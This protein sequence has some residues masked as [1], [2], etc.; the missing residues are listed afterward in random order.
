M[1][2]GV[3][4]NGELVDTLEGTPQGASVSPLL[5]NVYL[6]VCPQRKSETM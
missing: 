5:A 1:S 4:E 6:H 2:A 3:I